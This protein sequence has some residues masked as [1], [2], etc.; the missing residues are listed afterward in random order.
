MTTTM[1]HESGPRSETLDELAWAIDRDGIGR[2]ETAIARVVTLA[3]A[4]GYD[5][6]VLDVLADPTQA[7]AARERAFGTLARAVAGV[8]AGGRVG[9]RRDPRLVAA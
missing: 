7:P 9:H 5:P 3:R 6:V 2:H 4:T 8:S 1:T